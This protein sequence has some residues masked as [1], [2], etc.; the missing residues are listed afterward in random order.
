MPDVM[1][2]GSTHNLFSN[3]YIPGTVL[4][5]GIITKLTV[6][7]GVVGTCLLS[8]HPGSRDR[9]IDLCVFQASLV[10]LE[11]SKTARAP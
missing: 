1:N 2:F 8:Q 11:N 5:P 6:E 3:N 4:S 7:P 10:Y 9:Q